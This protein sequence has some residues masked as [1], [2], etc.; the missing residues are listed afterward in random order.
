MIGVFFFLFVFQMF[1]E[2]SVGLS[3]EETIFTIIF[4]FLFFIFF[5]LMVL[6]DFSSL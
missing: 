3:L 5:F 4:Y 6:R 2:R 1:V